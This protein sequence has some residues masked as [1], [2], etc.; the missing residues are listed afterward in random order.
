MIEI[1]PEVRLDLGF[2]LVELGFGLDPQLTLPPLCLADEPGRGLSQGVAVARARDASCRPV[3][4]W[5]PHHWRRYS[6]HP[7]D[8]NGICCWTLVSPDSDLKGCCSKDRPKID[9]PCLCSN[10][11]RKYRFSNG[12]GWI[13]KVKHRIL[14]LQTLCEFNQNKS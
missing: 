5:R 3:G 7:Q 11:Q 12:A 13:L 4:M 8:E 10:T 2:G 14:C 9:S 1:L 6:S